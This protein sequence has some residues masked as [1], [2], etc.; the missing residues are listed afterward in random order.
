M[1]Y[2]IVIILS[3]VNNLKMNI[4]GSGLHCIVVL[5]LRMMNLNMHMY[6]QCLCYALHFSGFLALLQNILKF[7]TLCCGLLVSVVYNLKIII[8]FS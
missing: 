4:P 2:I 8:L 6:I 3:S 1:W 5:M 7:S